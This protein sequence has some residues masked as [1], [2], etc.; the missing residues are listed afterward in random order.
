MI[1][2][3]GDPILLGFRRLFTILL[4]ISR[5]CFEARYREEEPPITQ[6]GDTRNRGLTT[7]AHQ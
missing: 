4:A 6:R 1:L 3:P 5:A 7:N 2:G